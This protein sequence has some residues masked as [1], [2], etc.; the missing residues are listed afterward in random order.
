M[1]V[2]LTIFGAVSK[3]KTQSLCTSQ[4]EFVQKDDSVTQ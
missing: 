2:D 3:V 1:K 4:D